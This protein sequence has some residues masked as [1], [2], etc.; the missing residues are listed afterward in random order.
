M[1]TFANAQMRYD[2]YPLAII[3][4]AMDRNAYAELVDNFPHISLF[5]KLSKFDY[6]V[7]LS[8]KFNPSNYHQFIAAN[9]PWNKFHS[10]V[11]SDDFIRQVGGFLKSRSIDLG[12]EDY[13]R[14]FG[15]RVGDLV[16]RLA[17]GR[18]P[19]LG[20]RLE[21]LFRVFRP[22]GGRR[23]GGA[24][25]GRPSQDRDAGHDNDQGWRM[26]PPISAV[27]LIST[28]RP[29]MPINLTGRIQIVP[30]DKIEVVETVPFVPNQCMI[31]VKTFNSLH[32]VKPM[33]GKGSEALRKSVTIVLESG[34]L[35]ATV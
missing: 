7:S 19:S 11:K 2:P 28:V 16:K 26:A 15:E 6:K 10:W 18:L 14:S 3:N 33:R 31:F 13:T 24:S 25:Y 9:K 20:Q 34:R 23:R 35:N 32:S 21:E 17:R 22:Q 12:L 5:G 29:M 8:E 1:L 4:P 30:W 27:D